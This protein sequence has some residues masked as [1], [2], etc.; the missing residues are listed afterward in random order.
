VIRVLCHYGFV[1]LGLHRLQLETL[2]DN[3]AMI[4]AATRCGFTLEGTLRRAA[5]VTGEFLDEIVMGL[6]ADEWSMREP[7]RSA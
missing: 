2:A 6:L 1:V 4:A 3:A 5:W 7:G